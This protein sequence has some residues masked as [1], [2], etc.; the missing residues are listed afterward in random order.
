[1]RPWWWTSTKKPGR[2]RP[3]A[4]AP[5]PGGPA[6]RQSDPKRRGLRG[7]GYSAG[8]A[9]PQFAQPAA[10]AAAQGFRGGTRPAKAAP[11][12]ADNDAMLAATGPQSAVLGVFMQFDP[13]KVPASSLPRP[14]V[15]PSRRPQARRRRAIPCCAPAVGHLVRGCLY[16]ATIFT[17]TSPCV[18]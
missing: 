16:W 4:L 2:I 13:Y 6:H 18:P 9:G 7:S 1:M 10:P 11:G 17:P 12:L 8:R 14:R 5:L 3:V 15:W